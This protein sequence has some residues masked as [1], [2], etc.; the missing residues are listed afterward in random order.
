[1]ERVNGKN[2]MNSSRTF[3]SVGITDISKNGYLKSHTIMNAR[4]NFKQA[5][6]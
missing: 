6:K 3:V 5:K 2:I 4:R 1:M